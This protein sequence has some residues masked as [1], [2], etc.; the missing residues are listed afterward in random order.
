MPGY[1]ENQAREAVAASFSYAETLRR[2]DLCPT[3]GN[4]SLLKT[5]LERWAIDTSHF[6]MR[7]RRS[8]RVRTAQPLTEILV[9]R[10]T[11][12]RSNLRARLYAEGLKVPVC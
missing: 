8:D 11:Y 12:A 2:L 9:E 4:T 5:W 10:S 3:G 1:E 7:A 6:D